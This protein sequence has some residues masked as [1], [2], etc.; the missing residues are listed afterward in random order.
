MMKEY[1]EHY[2]EWLNQKSPQRVES[3]QSVEAN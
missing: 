1:E 2:V 3:R